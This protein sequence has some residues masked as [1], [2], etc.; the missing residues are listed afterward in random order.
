MSSFSIDKAQ[1]IEPD[2][3]SG[4]G[5]ERLLQSNDLM[6]K[7]TGLGTFGMRA[8][9]KSEANPYELAVADSYVAVIWPLKQFVLSEYLRYY[10]IFNCM[11]G[12]IETAGHQVILAFEH[13]I[14]S[15]KLP[16]N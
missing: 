12:L 13:Y 9:Y 14:T 7:S 15:C 5:S 10:F 3:L 8:I 16:G 6:W 2:S 1:F 11:K 4:Y